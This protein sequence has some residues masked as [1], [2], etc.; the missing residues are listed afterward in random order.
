M[1]TRKQSTTLEGY[2]DILA[3][4]LHTFCEPA[5]VFLINR[6]HHGDKKILATSEKNQSSPAIWCTSF[7]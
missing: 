5:T 3:K 1:I 2:V 7:F 4:C 6:Y